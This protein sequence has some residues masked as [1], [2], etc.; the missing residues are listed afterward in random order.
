LQARTAALSHTLLHAR[1]LSFTHPVLGKPM[2]LAVPRP[3]TFEAFLREIEE[4]DR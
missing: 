1:Q 4:Q 3:A 2:V